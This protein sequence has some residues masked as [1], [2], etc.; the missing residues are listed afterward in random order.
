[1]IVSGIDVETGLGMEVEFDTH[2]PRGRTS[3][4]TPTV[5]LAGLCRCSGEWLRRGGLQFTRHSLEEIERSIGV[6]HSTGVARFLPTV[7]TGPAGGHGGGAAESGA[8]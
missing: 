6:I 4:F 7:I 2:H 5:P 3:R 8:A 1:M